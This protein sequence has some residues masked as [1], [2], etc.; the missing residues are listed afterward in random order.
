MITLDEYIMEAIQA[1]QQTCTTIDFIDSGAWIPNDDPSEDDYKTIF[2]AFRRKYP[3]SHNDRRVVLNTDV[4]C[5][6]THVYGEECIVFTFHWNGLPKNK[7]ID[8]VE[9]IINLLTGSTYS[10]KGGKHEI[11]KLL[12]IMSNQ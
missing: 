1:E 6:I 11:M 3:V 9:E 8:V 5:E 7:R 4:K 2:N 12:D 10:V